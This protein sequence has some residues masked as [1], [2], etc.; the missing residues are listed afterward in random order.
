[1]PQPVDLRA[2]A[3]PAPLLHILEALDHEPV[4]PLAFLVPLEPWP[5][6]PLLAARRWRYR[7]DP[8]PDGWTITL[9]RDP[10]LP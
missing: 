3:P 8:A 7:L 2:L 1:M 5:L 6:Y 4:G 9:F 10:P